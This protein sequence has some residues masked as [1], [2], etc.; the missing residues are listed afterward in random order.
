ML[1]REENEKDYV[2]IRQLVKDAFSTCPHSDGSEY[3]LIDK[4]RKSSG[5]IKQLTQVA[6][7]DNNIVG[8][9]MCTEVKIGKEIGIAIAPL[10]VLVEKQRQG[11]GKMLLEDTHK[12]A[13]S[14]GYRI[15]VVL[16]SEEYYPKFGYLK[17]SDFEIK[18]PFE[19]PEENYMV[20]FLDNV[21][22]NISGTVEY[23]KE[24]QI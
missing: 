20:L 23:V 8:H 11:I 13:L 9:I 2:K 4:L 16:G 6:I 24:L 14:L 5:F 15:A 10:S 19:V 22:R 1:I 18:S 3:I 7:Q 12:K 21:K 17:A